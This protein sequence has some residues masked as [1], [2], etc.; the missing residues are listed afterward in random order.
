VQPKGIKLGKTKEF[1]WRRD[2][3]EMKKTVFNY[4]ATF[5]LFETQFGEFLDRVSDIKRFA[6]LAEYYTG[7]SVDYL[8]PSGALGKYFPDWVGSEDCRR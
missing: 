6:A 7:F 5:N 4:V 2:W 1:A 8:K 3:S